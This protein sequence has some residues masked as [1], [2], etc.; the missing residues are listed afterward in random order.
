MWNS[1]NNT[2]LL[3]RLNYYLKIVLVLGPKKK[4]YYILA[5]GKVHINLL[6]FFRS[7]L[8]FN[9][10]NYLMSAQKKVHRTHKKVYESITN[11]KSPPFNPS[12]HLPSPPLLTYQQLET[13]HISNHC[14]CCFCCCCHHHFNVL[15]KFVVP[16]T[17]AAVTATA[18]STH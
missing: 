13:C 2:I 17:K 15:H 1:N 18:V 8:L 6:V 7:T 9:A 16:Y 10:L 14:C 11:K 4:L 3:H 5:S 12:P